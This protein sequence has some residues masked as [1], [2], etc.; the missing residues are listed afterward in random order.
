MAAGGKTVRYDFHTYAHTA[1]FACVCTYDETTTWRSNEFCPTKRAAKQQAAEGVLRQL[2][3][4]T[5][6]RHRLDTLARK[7]RKVLKYSFDD[8][9]TCT[10]QFGETVVTSPVG[11]FTDRDEACTAAAQEML[12]TVGT[13]SVVYIKYNDLWCGRD[14]H[15]VLQRVDD[16]SGQIQQKCIEICQ[17]D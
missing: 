9:G 14:T 12:F 8:N 10:C 7:S 4:N 6:A 11:V 1:G 17:D 3:D 15:I 13:H 16:T 5:N 2:G